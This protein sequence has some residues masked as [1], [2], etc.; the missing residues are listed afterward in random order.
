M[1][2]ESFHIQIDLVCFVARD[3]IVYIHS[4]YQGTYTET[5]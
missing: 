4:Y 5:W 1:K 2:Q 3:A